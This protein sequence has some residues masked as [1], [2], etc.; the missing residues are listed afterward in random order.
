[1]RKTVRAE[2][3]ES[4]LGPPR[5]AVV[6]KF[7][8]F[9]EEWAGLQL[10]RGV[11]HFRCQCICQPT[12]QTFSSTHTIN[13]NCRQKCSTEYLKLL[14]PW[15]LYVAIWQLLLHAIVWL[16]FLYVIFWRDFHSSGVEPSSSA[17]EP[18]SS[19]VAVTDA[20]VSGYGK[21]IWG[22]QSVIINHRAIAV[23]MTQPSPLK[24]AVSCT[25]VNK[26][27]WI[28]IYNFESIK[29]WFG[30][31]ALGIWMNSSSWFLWS[32]V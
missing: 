10:E 11:K 24:Q 32:T 16:T 27:T 21:V 17:P 31:R 4:P 5:E 14:L 2:W 1:M 6:I 22:V 25:N 28:L 15:V 20:A 12:C 26:H 8:Y 13:N 9:T 29:S 7:A 19:R 18:L 23:Y 3:R 30:Q